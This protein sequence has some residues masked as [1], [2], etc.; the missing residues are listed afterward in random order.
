MAIADTYSRDNF[1]LIKPQLSDLRK[2][3]IQ[4][5]SIDTYAKKLWLNRNDPEDRKKL[6]NLKVSLS[7]AFIYRQLNSPSDPRYDTFFASTLKNN[8]EDFN[9][10]IRI[11]SWNYDFQFEKAYSLYYKKKTL[12]DIQEKLNVSPPFHEN[13]HSNSR[14][15]ICKLNGTTAFFDNDKKGFV[16][17]I[18]DFTNANY[19][20]GEILSDKFKE[21]MVVTFC[22]Y[23]HRAVT[24]GTLTCLLTFA[25]ETMNEGEL[26][27]KVVDKALKSIDNTHALVI[28]GYSNSQLDAILLSS[29]L[30]TTSA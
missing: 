23:Y 24:L 16:N 13:H 17:P 7:F 4:H 25:W 11:I 3:T 2:N 5:A 21:G 20:D 19:N 12:E 6:I 26:S 1:E 29:L 10:D 18:Q 9:N 27:G 8:I 30:K 15:S 28:I 22:D 14:F